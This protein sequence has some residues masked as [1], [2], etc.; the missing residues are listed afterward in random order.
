MMRSDDP[1]D[2]NS[3]SRATDPNNARER[4]LKRY[5]QST[6]IIGVLLKIKLLRGNYSK[7]P[8]SN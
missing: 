1:T 3:W 2:P 4:T 7:T 8:S 6:L 5:I